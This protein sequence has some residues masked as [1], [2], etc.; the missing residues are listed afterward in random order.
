MER[1]GDAAVWDMT[2]AMRVKFTA[3]AMAVRLTEAL[4]ATRERTLTFVD[5]D[6]FWGDG[7]G[8]GGSNELGKI[9]MAVRDEVKAAAVTVPA[10]THEAGQKRARDDDDIGDEGAQ[11]RVKSSDAEEW[12]LDLDVAEAENT[13]EYYE[14]DAIDYG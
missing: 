13:T 12:T 4:L 9:L 14:E 1:K 5:E 2:E 10:V 6:E 3:S 11:K 8:G 7:R